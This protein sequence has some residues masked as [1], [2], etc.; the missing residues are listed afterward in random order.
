MENSQ[1]TT[2]ILVGIVIL[3]V[4]VFMGIKMSDFQKN[5]EEKT[6]APASEENN[7]LLEENEEATSS[8]NNDIQSSEPEINEST[9]EERAN[10][11]VSPSDAASYSENDLPVDPNST[12]DPGTAAIVND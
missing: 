10:R 2:K 6:S 1:K 4:L 7:A 5:A 9:P 11:T 3:I 8:E 12:M